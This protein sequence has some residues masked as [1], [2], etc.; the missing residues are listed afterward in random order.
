VESTKDRFP[1]FSLH[2]TKPW[3]NCSRPNLKNQNAKD[4]IGDNPSRILTG[5]PITDKKDP[6]EGGMRRQKEVSLPH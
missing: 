5:R 4:V 6:K 3:T 1:F 2:S